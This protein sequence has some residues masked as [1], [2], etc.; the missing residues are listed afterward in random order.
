MWIR[1]V[2]IPE[3]TDY[4]EYL[5][6]LGDYIQTLNNVDRVE[7]L[8]YHTM[9]IVK[10]EKM[11]IKYPLAGIEPPTHDRVVNAERLLHTADYPKQQR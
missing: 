4:D 5:T 11:G 9:G 8:P 6:R 10:Y 2:L 3:R 1:H 7:V